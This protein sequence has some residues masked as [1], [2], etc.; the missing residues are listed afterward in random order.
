MDIYKHISIIYTHTHTHTL[1]ERGGKKKELDG[2]E[3]MGRVLDGPQSPLVRRPV[4]TWKFFCPAR[5]NLYNFFLYIFRCVCVFQPS[6]PSVC[7]CM[8]VSVSVSTHRL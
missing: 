6:P 4:V 2:R 5:T 8:F 7:V 3:R 1:A